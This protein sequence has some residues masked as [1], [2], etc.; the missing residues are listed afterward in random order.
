[1]YCPKWLFC[2]YRWKDYFACRA[3]FEELVPTLLFINDFTMKSV[4]FNI[5]GFL[6]K[7]KQAV[8]LILDLQ[9]KRQQNEDSGGKNFNLPKSY[10][11]FFF[12]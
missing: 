2:H 10:Y 6:L 1:M 3:L 9:Y 12:F 11:R 4:I 8:T 7:I 5:E